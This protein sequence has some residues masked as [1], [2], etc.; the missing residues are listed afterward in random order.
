M[1]FPAYE[2]FQDSGRRWLGDFPTHWE[3]K[4]LWTM[5]RRTKRTGYANEELLSVYRDYGVIPKS[6]R[7][8]NFNKPSEDLSPYQLVEPSDLVINKMKAWQGSV[9]ISEHRGIVSPAYHVYEC[10][11]DQDSR[12]LHYLMRSP[13]YIT[14][15]LAMSKGI[16]VNQWDL[17]PQL[18]SRMPVLLPPLNEQ[19]AISSFLDVET[20]KIDGLVTEQRRMIELLKEKR[21]SVIS[22]S[23][24]KGL[25]PNAPMKPSGIQWLGDVPEHWSV[26]RLSYFATIENGSTPSR[27]NLDYWD[28]GTVPWVSSG[29]VNQYRVNQP[30]ELITEQAL[31][32]CPVRL[33]PKGT[34]VVGMIGQG[35]TRG[36]AAIL[37]I[38]AT[39]N[40][41]LAAIVPGDKLKSAYL[42][43]I[44]QAIYV[45]LREF[46]RGG[47]QAALNCQILG[48]MTIP[49]P[50]VEEQ[51]TICDYVEQRLQKF[52]LLQAEAERAI[53]LLQ[54]RRTALISAAVTGK[55]DVRNA[56]PKELI[57][58]EN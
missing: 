42:H 45:F 34:V 53:D 8:D 41:N 35:K 10:L 1:S 25:N 14:G 47:N 15:Y 18:H 3:S 58:N 23:V 54:E 9:A 29:G 21:Q 20:S 30:S 52:D 55:I 48:A 7:D 36:L 5:F 26:T 4:P 27:D 57:A 12:Y 50:P 44:F 37:D 28:N 17:E 40:Q 6:S 49:V 22:H 19:R 56:A 51:A 32:D 43:F 38:E 24:T 2:H 16:R 13:R 39:I 33:L 31:A 11:H 46:G